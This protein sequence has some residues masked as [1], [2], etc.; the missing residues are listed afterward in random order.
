MT[1]PSAFSL[2]QSEFNEFLFAPIGEESNGMPL[3]VASA[4]AHLDIDPWQEAA[5]LA[6]LPVEL[7]ATALDRLIRLLPAGRWNQAETPKIAARL[8][9]LLPRHG[10]VVPAGKAEAAESEPEQKSAN[11]S[12]ALWLIKLAGS[13]QLPA[14]AVERA[15]ACG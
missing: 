5:R 12:T 4:L 9:G 15:R 8:I 11:S 14:M 3:S 7:A 1:I 2:P 6:D 10:K 13:G